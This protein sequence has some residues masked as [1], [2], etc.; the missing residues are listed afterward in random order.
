MR[1]VSKGICLQWAERHCHSRVV[2]LGPLIR[3]EETVVRKWE[4]QELGEME[5]KRRRH[6]HTHIVIGVSCLQEAFL[7]L[8]SGQFLEPLLCLSLPIPLLCLVFPADWLCLGV[9]PIP[10]V[11]APG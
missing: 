1:G 2:C 11:E 8:S 4:E 6:T 7:D 9:F 5:T 3:A 10:G